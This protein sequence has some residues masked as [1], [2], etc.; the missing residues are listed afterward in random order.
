MEILIVKTSAL[1]DVIQALPVLDALE[2]HAVDWVIEERFLPLIQ[3]HP[4]IRRAIPISMESP[5]SS[6]RAVRQS[7]YDLVFD[8][9]GNCKSGLFALAARAPTKVGFGFKTVREW[10]NLF[11]THRHYNPPPHLN[12][13]L[14]YLHLIESY[15]QK[16]MPLKIITPV[17][18]PLKTV[19]VCPGSKWIN[20]QLP[21]NTWIA[22]LK[23]IDA[24]FLFVWGDEREKMMCEQ[25]QKQLG[26]VVSKKLS[27]SEW[28]QRMR[29]VDL[30]IAVDSSALHLAGMTQTPTFS[31]FGPTSP[32][33]FKPL[34]DH[35]K[36]YWGKCP[37]SR[38]F[39]KTCPVLRTCPT[40]ACMNDI[41]A[42][43]LYETFIKNL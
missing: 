22:F 16:P 9:Q 34:G 43:D 3:S 42:G 23:K 18:R 21:L 40:G 33:L 11:A 29:E 12:M 41:C 5:L 37:Y 36:S 39:V 20:K 7:R 25:M 6:L 4:L 30:V 2:G 32:E 38:Q 27:L 19:M 8:L 15:F 28:E 10:P 14:Q 31:I 1:G 26:G 17:S 24:S 35:H 13:R